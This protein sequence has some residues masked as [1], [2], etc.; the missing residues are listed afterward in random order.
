MGFCGKWTKL[1]DIRMEGTVVEKFYNCNY[2]SNLISFE[3]LI[4]TEV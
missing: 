4:N 1:V 2:L 3:E